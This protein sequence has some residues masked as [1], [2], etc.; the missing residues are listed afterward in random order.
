MSS[1]QGPFY[2]QRLFSGPLGTLMLGPTTV[3]CFSRTSLAQTNLQLIAIL[4]P[5]LPKCWGI[6][7]SLHKLS[8]PSCQHTHIT[9]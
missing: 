2:S 7:Y 3:R 6:N 4:L 5:Q 9:G 1:R 8:S